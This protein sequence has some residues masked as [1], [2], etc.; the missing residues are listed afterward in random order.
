MFIPK[1]QMQEI[2]SVRPAPSCVIQSRA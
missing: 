2:K 1:Q